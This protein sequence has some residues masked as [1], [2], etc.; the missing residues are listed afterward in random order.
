MK[1]P[2]SDAG[3]AG[4]SPGTGVYAASDPAILFAAAF[5]RNQTPMSSEAKRTG[6]TFVTYDSPTGERQS[7]P[8]VWNAYAATSQKGLTSTP[9]SAREPPITMKTKPVASNARPSAI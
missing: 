1:P 2:M 5:A 7:S 4:F 8:N 9:V 6:A 3:A